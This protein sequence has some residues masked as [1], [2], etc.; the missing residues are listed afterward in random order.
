MISRSRKVG[1]S[2]HNLLV[3]CAVIDKSETFIEL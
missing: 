2:V 1:K 3:D